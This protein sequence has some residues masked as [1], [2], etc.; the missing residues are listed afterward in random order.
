MQEP[1]G[2]DSGSPDGDLPGE[3][4]QAGQGA[5]QLALTV[6]D[7]PGDPDD[8]PAPGGG[9]DP[10][11]PGPVRPSSTKFAASSASRV[12]LRREGRVELA[13]DDQGQQLVVGDVGDRAEVPR[14][15][16]SRRTVTRSASSRTS[17][18]RCVM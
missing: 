17:A 6:A 1:A 5:E 12:V 10:G 7:H 8:L 15:R 11:E 16:P 9:A 4:L 14:S 2:G 18:M 13:P 3:R